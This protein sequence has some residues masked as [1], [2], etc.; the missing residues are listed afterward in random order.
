[1]SIKKLV[2]TA[3]MGAMMVPVAIGFSGCN[4]KAKF[5]I[6]A[7]DV[8]A[9]C[10]S[11]S[12]EYLQKLAPQAS[13]VN[14]LSS[15]TRPTIVTDEDIEGIKNNLSMFDNIVSSGLRQNVSINTSQDPLYADY[16]FVMEISFPSLQGMDSYKMYYSEKN[17][18]THEEIDD[19]GYEA[20]F[21]TTIE[22]VIVVN[23]TNYHIQ[24]EREFE[25]EGKEKESSIE[26][27]TYLDNNNYIIYEQSVEDNE[28]EYEYTIFKN[29]QKL[30]ET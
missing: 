11:S 12:V 14:P 20:E 24:G 8:Y 3:I 6:N 18:T 13:G 15:Q 9:L 21:S 22:G 28:V 16:T 30:Q 1:M 27:K 29:G 19:E 4:E 26:F 10:A 23:G 17:A 5:D 2:T 25:V 7:K